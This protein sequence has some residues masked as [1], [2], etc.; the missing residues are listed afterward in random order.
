MAVDAA[1]ETVK[2]LASGLDVL[3]GALGQMQDPKAGPVMDR[4][5]LDPAAAL[6]GASDADLDLLIAAYGL[7][8][9]DARK[10]YDLRE[11]LKPIGG[12]DRLISAWNA[13]VEDA[14]QKSDEELRRQEE[15][16]RAAA[17]NRAQNIK[18][19][20]T[21]RE[22]L[23][24]ALQ[25]AVN[26]G[27]SL[28]PYLL[29]RAQEPNIKGSLFDPF[30][31]TSPE[32]PKPS[33]VYLKTYQIL[34]RVLEPGIKSILE[35]D[36]ADLQATILQK[37]AQVAQLHA[38]FEN[39]FAS[40][41]TPGEAPIEWATA[42]ISDIQARMNASMIAK[43]T[44]V[45]AR[46]G[47]NLATNQRIDGIVRAL[48]SGV[49]HAPAA[50]HGTGFTIQAF[51][52]TAIPAFYDLIDS[53]L[54]VRV[55]VN[56]RTGFPPSD[57][58][59][60]VAKENLRDK[61][62]RNN[63]AISYP[64]SLKY[65]PFTAI[66]D[67]GKA[68]GDGDGVDIPKD[69]GKLFTHFRENGKDSG[70]KPMHLLYSAFGYSGSGKSH[71]LFNG[72]DPRPL[73]LQVL[74][75]IKKAKNADHTLEVSMLLYDYYGEINDRECTEVSS[76]RVA[77]PY[78]G[79]EQITYFQY[80]PD[81]AMKP[82]S[83][84]AL[85]DTTFEAPAD[86]G[87]RFQYASAPPRNMDL[88]PYMIELPDEAALDKV[89]D[90]YNKLN[91]Y[92]VNTN[93]GTGGAQRYHIR[94][95]PNNPESSRAH[96]FL[97]LYLRKDDKTVGKITIMDMAGT[98]D[99][100][101]IQRNYF[102]VVPYT[103]YEIDGSSTFGILGD[104]PQDIMTKT[105]YPSSLKNVVVEFKERSISTAMYIIADTQPW[106]ELY[107]RYAAVWTP[108]AAKQFLEFIVWNNVVSYKDVINNY[109]KA[110]QQLQ[111][112][113][114]GFADVPCNGIKPNMD[115]SETKDSLIRCFG[116]MLIGTRSVNAKTIDNFVENF[117]KA[118]EANS[119]EISKKL[120]QI[121]SMRAELTETM[122]TGENLHC[123]KIDNKD[124]SA[125]VDFDRARF[126]D[127]RK[128]I[129]EKNPDW[130]D[131]LSELE[132]KLETIIKD[133]ATSYSLDEYKTK[134][135]GS[136]RENLLESGAAY[137]SFLA[138]QKE[139][140]KK[141]ITKYHCPLR[142][143]GVF[144]NRTLGFLK[145][146]VQR[147]VDPSGVP[148][149]PNNLTDLCMASDAY[150]GDGWSTRFVLFVN[151]RLDFHMNARENDER[152]E[153]YRETLPIA[154][155]FAHDVNPFQATGK[156]WYDAKSIIGGKAKMMVGTEI[157]PPFDSS[158]G[159]GIIMAKTGLRGEVRYLLAAPVA[160]AL[161]MALGD[162]A[163]VGKGPRARTRRLAVVLVAYALA[164]AVAQA[165]LG[166]PAGILGTHLTWLAFG[167]MGIGATGELLGDMLTRRAE[168]GATVAL[169]LLCLIGG[170]FA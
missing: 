84:K 72:T 68:T 34:S 117:N 18:T 48:Q 169:W 4:G 157:V 31:S 107:L 121:R 170:F 32:P 123:F 19:L 139:A 59:G 64:G 81:D 95:T 114:L 129:L 160:M 130:K 30:W 63:G 6:L 44:E 100:D 40:F 39:F 53:L 11:S 101:A 2:L 85:V 15:E 148:K 155:G 162:R 3:R 93:F 71:L 61:I 47:D 88:H 104:L 78:D 116:N 133:Q 91:N 80:N 147:I 79:S 77:D 45:K 165:A 70:F 106:I 168:D 132:H 55:M 82:F 65:G 115:A 152:H 37:A 159:G 25:D 112:N 14:K 22:M 143:Q 5:A 89:P 158:R 16:A 76:G 52:E 10:L 7:D 144:I 103:K 46:A 20:D 120:G 43:L 166:F 33:E 75:E 94:M 9:A 12:M 163:R 69:L 149:I 161:A 127:I 141:I 113:H 150:N 99:V 60:P 142:F 118:W 29:E 137:R 146:Y 50:L 109:Q 102:G 57:P 17:A 21:S 58:Y 23:I 8:K 111:L 126:D 156:G 136:M 138:K 54:P 35:P 27:G 98:E 119:T 56:F 145:N 164:M 13:Y 49:E 96:L 38:T 24:K 140:F 131:A 87:D 62:Q 128:S 1:G 108:D 125:K 42:T 134:K 83:H 153:S 105:K 124:G 28:Y 51:D 154:L 41:P 67:G 151:I 86:G 135:K 36:S 110:S 97:D 167:L 26:P 90:I 73:F 66:L 74:D 122:K 92:R